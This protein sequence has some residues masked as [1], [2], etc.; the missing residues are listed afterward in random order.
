MGLEV[1]KTAVTAVDKV[2]DDCFQLISLFF[3]TVGRNNEAPAV[4]ATTSTIKVDLVYSDAMMIFS[5]YIYT[6]ALGSSHGG[7][8]VL[9]KRP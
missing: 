6:A 7:Q 1:A 2:L 9:R 8:V 4:Y 3:M 5:D